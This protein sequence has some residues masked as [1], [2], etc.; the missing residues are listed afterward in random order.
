M[1]LSATESESSRFLEELK[2]NYRRRIEEVD[3]FSKHFSS[4]S[5]DFRSQCLNGILDVLQYY[6]DL[7]KKFSSNMPD[8]Y[9]GEF[10]IRQSKMITEAWTKTV[11]GFD[12]AYS[13]FADYSIRNMR[14]C[15]QSWIQMM[16]YAE[17][18]YD[19]QENMP[20]ISKNT[21]I[22]IIKEA[23]KANDVYLEKQFPTKENGNSK[24]KK[25]TLE[26]KLE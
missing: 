4:S 13:R 9:D 7:N 23:K 12:Q 3:A 16:Q 22:E 11:Q 1:I 10:M 24:K 14:L 8:W 20:Q 2:L 17:R 5:S 18:F 19:M 26:T 6:V 25:Q 15:N 21:M